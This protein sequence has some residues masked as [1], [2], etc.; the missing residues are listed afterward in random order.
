[1]AISHEALLAEVLAACHTTPIVERYIRDDEEH[2]FGCVEGAAV[3]VNPAPS[4][5][6]TLI[7]E[8]VHRLHPRWTEAYVRRRAW[9][10]VTRMTTEEV[11]A[12]YRLYRR[13]KRNG[14]PLQL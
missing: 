7:H 14:R 9:A 1:M 12:A 13:R 3:H 11:E 8:I 5:V 6:D 4:T 10:L 2:V